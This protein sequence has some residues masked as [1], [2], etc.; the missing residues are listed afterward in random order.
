MCVWKAHHGG[1]VLCTLSLHFLLYSIPGSGTQKTETRSCT[2]TYTE[3]HKNEWTA[4]C[5]LLPVMTSPPP[6]P[7]PARPDFIKRMT[8]APIYVTTCFEHAL[9]L[10]YSLNMF[11]S[12]I[13]LFFTSRALPPKRTAKCFRLWMRAG[14]QKHLSSLVAWLEWAL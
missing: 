8:R 12:V 9:Y 5:P 11:L 4:W 10:G 7:L 6:V 3:T 2:H 1:V 14:E 13:D